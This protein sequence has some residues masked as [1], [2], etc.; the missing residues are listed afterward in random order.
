M[1]SNRIVSRITLWTWG[2]SAFFIVGTATATPN[3][4][5]PR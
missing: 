1:K 3:W 5:R 4:H 2:L